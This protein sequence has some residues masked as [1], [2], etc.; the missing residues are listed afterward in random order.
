MEQLSALVKQEIET[1]PAVESRI[2]GD[3]EE[4]WGGNEPNRVLIEAHLT[5]K[6]VGRPAAG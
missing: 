4:H 6:A 2:T 3:W 1:G 5:V